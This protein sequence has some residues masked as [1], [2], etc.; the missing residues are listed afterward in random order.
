MATYNRAIEED[1]H[2]QILTV[3][4]QDT[5]YAHNEA[6]LQSA[7]DYVGHSISSDT[8]HTRLHWLEE[9]GLIQLEDVGVLV[10]T[11]TRRGADVAQGRTRV[12]G[13]A[14]K[15]PGA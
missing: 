9:Q 14:R 3:L 10:A 11:L 8:L 12:P 1:Q 7:L 13:V 2:L 15:R 6:V 4:E 5:D